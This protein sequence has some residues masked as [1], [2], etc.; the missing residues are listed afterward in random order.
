MVADLNRTEAFAAIASLRRQTLWL[1]AALV[2]GIGLAAYLLGL[3]M[4]RPLDRLTHAAGRVAKD[5]L[6]VDL[7]IY[8][9]GEIDVEIDSN[10]FL[11]VTV[12]PDTRIRIIGQVEKERGETSLEADYFDIVER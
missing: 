11:M 5:D 4:V 10:Q 2:L 12:R 3:T 9:S 8:D 6:N 1:I 7:P